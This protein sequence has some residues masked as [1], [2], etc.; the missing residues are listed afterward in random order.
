M[1]FDPAKHH[2]QSIRLP[3]YDYTQ[4]GAYFVTLIAQQ[5]ECLFGA[6]V[7][8]E[9]RLNE[10]GELV[11]MGWRDLPR[12][13]ANLTL[14]E[15]VVMP[16]HLHGI[17]VLSK[18]EASAAEVLTRPNKVRADASPLPPHGTAPGSVGAILQ[19]YKSVTTRKINHQRR[20]PGIPV[21]QRNYYEHIIRDDAALARIRHYILNNPQ[22]WAS[23]DH[24]QHL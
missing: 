17:I 2:R 10:W 8:G 3:G 12:H 6:I 19:N 1:R 20:T 14:D 22:K 21:W 9:M 13:F 4:A 5:R 16:N 7:A 18:G 24:N 11:A 15:W 23:D